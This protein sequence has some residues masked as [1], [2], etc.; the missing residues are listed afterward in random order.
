MATENEIVAD[1]AYN[2]DRVRKETCL[3]CHLD[4]F[5][6]PP[7]R[8]NPFSQTSVTQ[9]AQGRKRSVLITFLVSIR[10]RSRLREWIFREDHSRNVQIVRVGSLR[11]YL[12]LLLLLLLTLEIRGTCLP[13]QARLA[14]QEAVLFDRATDDLLVQAVLAVVA[15]VVEC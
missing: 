2:L 14:V 15:V 5:K 8:P 6:D 9:I 13:V 4:S 3:Y 12:W 10:R 7:K 11:L 1:S